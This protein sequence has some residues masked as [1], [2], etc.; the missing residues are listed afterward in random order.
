MR[1]A[2][3]PANG[4]IELATGS[5]G[6]RG[7]RLHVRQWRRTLRSAP[8][9]GLFLVL[10]VLLVLPACMLLLGVVRSAPPSMNGHWTLAAFAEAWT[11]P[12][13]FGAVQNSIVIGVVTTGIGLVL[14]L[15]FAMTAQRT[16]A[17]VRRIITPLMLMMFATPSLFYAVG[18][19]LLANSAGGLLNTA[20][21]LAFG[22]P[23]DLLD[24][25]TW[26]G[27][28]AAMTFRATA[29]MYLFIVGPVA[30]LSRSAEEASLMSGFGPVATMW[31]INLPMLAPALTGAAILGF[32]ASLQAF[33]TALI[34]AEP[35]G[36]HVVSTEIYDLLTGSS[37]PRYALASLASVA[38]ILVVG[39][40][41]L[42][43][44]RM[45]GGRSFVTV[46]GRAQGA[47]RTRLGWAGPV[48]SALVVLYLLVAEVLP[49]ISLLVASL[50]RFPGVF[51]GM[52]PMHYVRAFHQPGVAQSFGTTLLLALV[53]GGGAMMLALLAAQIGRRLSSTGRATL[54]FVTLLPFA[55]PGIVTA[56]AITWAYVSLPGLRALYGTIWIMAVAL[57]VVVLPFTMQS[58][59]AALAQIGRELEEASRASGASPLR[60]TVRIV[61]PLIAPSFFAG[62]FVA[63]VIIAGNLDVPLLLGSP[64][65]TTIA[66]RIY[67]LNAQGQV[68]DAAA[69]LTVLLAGLAVLGAAGL[70]LRRLRRVRA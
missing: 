54:R 1:I 33:D 37:P 56:L 45:L 28:L 29:F 63:A 39:L 31:R 69:L 19:S 12:D 14:A 10:G 58:A 21:H 13:L 8:A 49:L 70:G 24:A 40:L 44:A 66:A 68:G 4:P 32:V 22:L 59:Q 61:A 46:S 5:P 17:A 62:W 3:S 34:L 7:S 20:L 47:R 51:T 41:V 11:D 26:P 18:Y 27:V 53:A 67:A 9:L 48:I 50:Q 38:L 15:A 64:G 57:I 60:T 16:D 6:R 43:Q 52:S 42:V 36:I 2:P 55:M 65:L 30:A 35:A 23:I 25:E